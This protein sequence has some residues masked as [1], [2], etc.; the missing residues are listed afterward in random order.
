MKAGTEVNC[1][2]DEWYEVKRRGTT[3]LRLVLERNSS[4]AF[5]GKGFTRYTYLTEQPGLIQFGDEISKLVDFAGAR[6]IDCRGML[7]IN[8]SAIVISLTLPSLND[9]ETNLISNGA[10][11]SLLLNLICWKRQKALPY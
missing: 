2:C 7:S 9:N 11:E 6:L 5:V 8:S 1:C 3:A 4:Y 10:S